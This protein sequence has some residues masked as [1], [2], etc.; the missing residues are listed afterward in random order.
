MKDFVLQSMDHDIQ[1][2][3]IHTT[4]VWSLHP[5][6]M[7]DYYAELKTAFAWDHSGHPP[8]REELRLLGEDIMWARDPFAADVLRESLCEAL[9]LILWYLVREDGGVVEDS[10]G[11]RLSVALAELTMARMYDMPYA[12]I[13]ELGG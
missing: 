8:T 9:F 7:D 2:I 13:D 4:I 5:E 1:E 10:W 3:V 11:V 12:N 6:A